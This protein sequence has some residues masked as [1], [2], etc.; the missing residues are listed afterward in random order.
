MK[1]V[2]KFV[3][4]GG[5]LVLVCLVAAMGCERA[6]SDVRDA[7]N[8][9]MRRALRAKQDQDI[10]RAI[11]ECQKALKRRPTLALAHRE[12]ALMLDNYRQD[13][14][15]AIYHYQRYLALRPDSPNREAVEE[16]IRFC[17]MN[18]AAEIGATP[19]EWQR[20]LQV[21]ND[22]IRTLETELALWRS[23]EMEAAAASVAAPR[24][25]TA[26]PAAPA[27]PTAAAPAA[28][29][30][31]HVVSAGETLGTIA[32]RYYGS[33]GHWNRIFKANQDHIQNPNNVR[34][35]ATL[36]IPAD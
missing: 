32:A 11:T 8:R 2:S 7:R 21:R 22:R 33:P 17:R 10:D 25:S 23:G 26:T 12:L 5:G 13:Y 3:R 20:D 27:A 36:V 6:P 18:F 24:R 16:L 14:V 35:G 19:E 15:G 1:R 4:M 28:A 31:T 30:R 9:Y 29:A 34:V